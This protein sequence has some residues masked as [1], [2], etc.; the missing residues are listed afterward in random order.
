MTDKIFPVTVI[1]LWRRPLVPRCLKGGGAET[2][3]D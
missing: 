3:P 2:A 1:C